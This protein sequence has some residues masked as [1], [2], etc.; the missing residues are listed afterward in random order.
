MAKQ[1]YRCAGCGIRTDPGEH[2]LPPPPPPGAA[3]SHTLGRGAGQ[4]GS[5]R[6]RHSRGGKGKEGAWIR[7]V[8][9]DKIT[10]N[11]REVISGGTLPALCTE[12]DWVLS[13]RFW[14]LD[15]T[16]S[17]RVC[18]LSGL[19]WGTQKPQAPLCGFLLA[20]GAH[21]EVDG[22]GWPSLPAL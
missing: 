12:E 4:K 22:A 9:L 7:E 21:T 2:V 6:R 17:G 11:Q 5:E 16:I 8:G 19:R 15:L 3:L 10:G 14:K 1:N 18:F 20:L 13:A